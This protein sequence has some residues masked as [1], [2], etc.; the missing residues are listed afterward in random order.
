MDFQNII[1][2]IIILAALFYVGQMLWRKAKSF[3]S[4]SST[5]AADCGCGDAKQNKKFV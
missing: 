2:A 3:S 5:C 1:V 4:K